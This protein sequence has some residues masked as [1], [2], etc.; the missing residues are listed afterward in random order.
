MYNI[1]NNNISNNKDNHYINKFYIFSLAPQSTF[2]VPTPAL[3]LKPG[4][5]H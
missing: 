4:I 3:I 2:A 1:N 5:W